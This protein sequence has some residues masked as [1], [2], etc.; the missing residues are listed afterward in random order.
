MTDLG[1]LNF[2][3]NLDHPSFQEGDH[4]H[5]FG[6]MFDLFKEV[7]LQNEEVIS[8]DLLDETHVHH[9]IRKEIKEPLNNISGHYQDGD[10]YKE[11]KLLCSWSRE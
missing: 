3:V 1:W 9:H 7:L 8:K 5:N 2:K 10:I 6:I 11:D 4:I